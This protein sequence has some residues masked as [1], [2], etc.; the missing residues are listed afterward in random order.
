MLV[1]R[2]DLM[3][4]LVARRPDVSVVVNDISEGATKWVTEN[5][6]F[7]TLRGG[8]DELAAHEGQYDVVV[9]SDVLYYEP[10]LRVLWDALSRLVSLGGSIVIR[11][12][13]KHILIALGQLWYHLTH[14]RAQ[15][16]MQDRI[17][18]FN[19]EHIFLFR[20]QYLRNRLM[21]MG[22]TQVQ[23]LPSPLLGGRRGRV[24]RSLLFSLARSANVLSRHRLVL[25][26][27]MIVVGRRLT[28]R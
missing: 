27:A 16:A 6:G 18:F 15:Q 19:P 24:L 23:A 22:F 9:L 11:V 1:A 5:L 12:P 8:A 21:S 2:G 4:Q 20:Q 14:T 10:N 7:A 26:P 13:N 3:A 25:K 17:R 28:G